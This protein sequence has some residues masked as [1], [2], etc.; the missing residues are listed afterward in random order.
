M[1]FNRDGRE[2]L[3]V[4]AEDGSLRYF[5]RE[6]DGGFQSRSGIFDQVGRFSTPVA[7]DFDRDG[8]REITPEELQRGM[9]A[10][11]FDRKFCRG[12]VEN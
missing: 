9:K 8:S 5:Q 4:G 3:L 7:L 12:L 1:D 11:G 2:D 6:E 10:G